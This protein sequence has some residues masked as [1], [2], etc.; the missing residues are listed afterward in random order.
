M[1]Y[2]LLFK[3]EAKKEWEKLDTAIK[4]QFKKKLVER[5]EFPRVESSR[6]NGMKVC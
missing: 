3:V 1:S 4:G 6:L 5:L 2:R